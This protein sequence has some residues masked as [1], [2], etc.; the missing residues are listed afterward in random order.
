M[1]LFR[2]KLL[3]SQLP[4]KEWENLRDTIMSVERELIILFTAFAVLFPA[5]REVLPFLNEYISGKDFEKALWDYAETTLTLLL[6]TLARQYPYVFKKIHFNEDI[7][8]SVRDFVKKGFYAATLVIFIAVLFDAVKAYVDTGVVEYI[9]PSTIIIAFTFYFLIE[10]SI[11]F[12]RLWVYY[13]YVLF[14]KTKS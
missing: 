11:Y 9:F 5:V 2:K 12:C 4:E 13:N 1:R 14:K 7:T 3:K 6:I 8:K 10:C